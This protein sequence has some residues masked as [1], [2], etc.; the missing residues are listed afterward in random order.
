MSLNIFSVHSPLPN[1]DIHPACVFGKP[2]CF[3][4]SDE[5]F[6]TLL[7]SIYRF[8]KPSTDAVFPPG[9]IFLERFRNNS[10]SFAY[11]C[12]ISPNYCAFASETRPSH[13]SLSYSVPVAV[14]PLSS[15]YEGIVA[16]FFFFLNISNFWLPPKEKGL[17]ISV[18]SCTEK[19]ACFLLLCLLFSPS[20]PLEFTQRMEDGFGWIKCHL[21][22]CGLGKCPL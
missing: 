13:E 3:C 16:S 19:T 21:Q 7:H 5:L 4:F 22:G 14:H 10:E 8:H 15:Y 9:V 17:L 20:A 11:C 18:S 6:P 1:P 12:Y 2:C